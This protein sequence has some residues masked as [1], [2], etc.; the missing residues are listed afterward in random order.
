MLE[1]TLSVS[2]VSMYVANVFEAEEMLHDIKMRGE[3][4]TFQIKSGIAY[5]TL[6]DNNSIINCITFGAERFGDIKI[7]DDVVI[8][9][10]VQYY[11]K[12]G[13]LNFNAYDIKPYG[14]GDIYKQFLLLKEKLEKAGFFDIKHK[15]PLPSNIK[16]IGVVTS[17]TGAV[18]Q[19]IIN[20]ATRRNPGINI[21]LYPAKVQ[22]AGADLTLIRGIEYFETTDVDVVIVGRGGGSYEDLQPFNSELLAKA[23]F[24]A[25]KVIVSAVGHETDFTIIDFVA[26]L[27]APT[28][29]AAAELVTKNIKEEI[30]KIAKD[31]ML[32]ESAIRKFLKQKLDEIVEN[33]DRLVYAMSDIVEQKKSNVYF[34]A[35]KLKLLSSK[36]YEEKLNKINICLTALNN[37]NPSQLLMKGYSQLYKNNKVV[38][39]VG[40]VE[41][42][43]EITAVL[44]DGV[45]KTKVIKI[46]ERE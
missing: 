44:K 17:S 2:E 39:S 9:G 24:D 13:R 35:N 8:T 30:K 7:G 31:K 36:I 14:L 10:S 23:V 11:A 20:V 5:Y 27:R 40:D 46:G 16:K 28:P 26:D 1:R 6:K 19:D 33:Q 42:N 22:G 4:S 37:L 29:S 25:S 32:L 38:S 43:D 34:I 12:G 41:I 21:E 45:V 15:K 3:I 18:I